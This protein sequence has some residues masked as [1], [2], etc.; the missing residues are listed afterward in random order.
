MA[1][2]RMDSGFSDQEAVRAFKKL[3][4]R[5]PPRSSVVVGVDTTRLEPAPRM[6]KHKPKQPLKKFKPMFLEK[7]LPALRRGQ[8]IRRREWHHQSFIFRV[9]GDVFV[10]LPSMFMR[11]PQIW[12]PYPQDLL[13]NDW[14]IIKK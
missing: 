10:K 1:Y 7:A 2:I 14:E 11:E 4:D 12:K 3:F 8:A 5:L 9:A 13:A 6:L